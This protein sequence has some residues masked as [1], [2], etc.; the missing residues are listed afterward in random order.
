MSRDDGS[1]DRELLGD[2]PAENE[3]KKEL[4]Q[5][6]LVVS[7]QDQLRIIDSKKKMN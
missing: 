6:R 7:Y 4:A 3:E 1:L 5:S 2:S